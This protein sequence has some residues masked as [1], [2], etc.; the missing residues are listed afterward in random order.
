M[1]DR[2]YLS[3]TQL[4]MYGKCPEM[5]RRRYVEGEKVPP[6][7]AMLKGTGLHRG[8][9]RN[10]RQKIDS[11]E[12]LPA[13]DIIDAAVAGFE[14]EQANGVLLAPD[15]A[16]R[17]AT[18]VLGEAKDAVVALAKAHAEMQAPEY[19]PVFVEQSIRLTLPGDRD[20]LGVID[21]ADDQRRVVDMKTAGKRK[22][23]GDADG[24]TQLTVYAALHQAATGT[25]P[26]LVRLDT[27]VSKKKGIERQ[28]VDSHR[29]EPDFAALANRINAVAAAI[30]AGVFPP[31]TPGAWWCSAKW[32]GY[33]AT[34]P[35]I[36]AQRKAAGEDS[37]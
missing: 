20:L 22:S 15:E 11:R 31:T 7:V 3:A 6:G 4:D 26:S 12:D 23:Q 9:E 1:S 34:C 16:A 18:V 32:C 25:M 10:F 8:A 33:H 27:L 37:E 2:P 35:Y 30:D 5:Y 21:L 13:S 28:A 24:S 19:Q 36:N 17:G 14:A 29:G